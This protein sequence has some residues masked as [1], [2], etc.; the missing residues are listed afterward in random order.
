MK[1]V[2]TKQ[3]AE[4][5]GVTSCTARILMRTHDLRECGAR[6]RAMNYYDRDRVLQVRQQRRDGTYIQ[7]VR[8]YR[9]SPKT[10]YK[11][12]RPCLLCGAGTTRPDGVCLSCSKGEINLDDPYQTRIVP[13]YQ[14]RRCPTCG[15]RLLEGQWECGDCKS[16]H[17]AD[18]DNLL[19]VDMAYGSCA[20]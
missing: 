15:A 17:L 2:T 18:W 9:R 12:K 7:P 11:K 4:R 5:L 14:K 13:T 20:L 8:K 1:L 10:Y 16:K 3:A 19:D 6:G